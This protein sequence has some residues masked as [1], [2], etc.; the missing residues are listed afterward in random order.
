MNLRLLLIPTF[1]ALAWA[2]PA[3]AQYPGNPSNAAQP[4][5]QLPAPSQVAPAKAPPPPAESAATA[6]P[7][8]TAAD[9]L[10]Q[11]PRH[12]C[13]VG[14]EYPAGNV[15][16]AKIIAFNRDYKTYADCIKK[17]IEENKAW[18]D[19]VRDVTNKAVEDYNAYSVNVKKQIDAAK[20]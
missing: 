7:A 8:I 10:P 19:A 1:A 5:L 18:M 9:V 6:T 2:V 3:L 14:P 16:D 20:E 15:P 11:V 13:G 17:Y 12:H 4:N